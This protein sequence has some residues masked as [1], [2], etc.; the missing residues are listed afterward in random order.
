MR[1]FNLT[2]MVIASLMV[3]SQA[4][5]LAQTEWVKVDSLM[6][7]FSLNLVSSMTKQPV[8]TKCGIP[9]NTMLLAQ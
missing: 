3:L 6:I 7:D 8:S 9:Q 2:I 5:L 1:R 4:S